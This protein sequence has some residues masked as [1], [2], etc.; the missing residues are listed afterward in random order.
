MMTLGGLGDAFA[1]V[2][3]ENSP[4]GA[5][6]PTATNLAA[7]Q[8]YVTDSGCLLATVIITNT[9]YHTTQLAMMIMMMIVSDFLSFSFTML[10]LF[11]VHV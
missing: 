10:Y 2:P 7:P 3:M 8:S 9:C 1:R 11:T 6:M 5:A 4:P